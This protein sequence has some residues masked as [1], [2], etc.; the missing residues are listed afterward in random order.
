MTDRQKK[1]SNV[2]YLLLQGAVITILIW[3]TGMAISKGDTA[4]DKA[5]TV[6][7]TQCGQTE[8][9]K[10]VAETLKEV[11]DDVKEIKR[12]MKK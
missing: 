1:A 10:Y 4:L 3:L 11:K 6:E 7:K 12:D 5:N 2:V 8:T 9:L